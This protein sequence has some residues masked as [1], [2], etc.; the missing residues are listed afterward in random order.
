[1]TQ[2]SILNSQLFSSTTRWQENIHFLLFSCFE[3]CK[4][5]FWPIACDHVW[6]KKKPSLCCET[7]CFNFAL[8]LQKPM[9]KEVDKDVSVVVNIN[10]SVESIFESKVIRFRVVLH[11]KCPLKKSGMDEKN[12]VLWKWKFVAYGKSSRFYSCFFMFF[13]QVI[14]GW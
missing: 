7:C 8:M 4:K 13:L 1:M 5:W 2:Q 3:P 10:K 9:S 12:F 14:R 11:V 6:S